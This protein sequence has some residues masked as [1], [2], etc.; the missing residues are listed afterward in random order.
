MSILLTGGT[1]FIGSAVLARLIETGHEVTAVVRSESS[2]AAVT[3][4]GATA[5]IGDVTD[6]DWLSGLLAESDG[7]IHAAVPSEGSAADFDDAVIDAVIAAFAGTSKRYIHTGG[8]WTWGSSS[9]IT[10]ESAPNPPA[11]TAWR[12]ARH[13]R[14]LESGI[15]ASIIAPGIVYGHGKGIPGILA[16]APVNADGARLLIGS[17]EQHW[18]TIH[19]DDLADLYVAVLDKGKRGEE[20][21]GASGANPTVRELGEAAAGARGS[22]VAESD[23]ATRARLGADFADALLL[24]Q[25]ASGAK[26][27]VDL[28]WAP[29]RPSL[30]SELVEASELRALSTPRD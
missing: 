16:G 28:G 10:E 29:T 1:G 6:V 13:E 5:V 14:L 21:I 25:Q 4:A 17:G 30:V 20:Y 3:A 12:V 8:I 26:A 18:T 23:D 15:A 19:V 2:A 9:T 22:V 11:L 7:A 27:R 24:D